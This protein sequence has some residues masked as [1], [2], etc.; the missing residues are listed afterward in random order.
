MDNLMF[1]VNSTSIVYTIEELEK[2][3]NTSNVH[4]VTFEYNYN[5]LNNKQYCSNLIEY[6][7]DK[8]NKINKKLSLPLAKDFKEMIIIQILEIIDL[9]NEKYNYLWKQLIE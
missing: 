6:D 2:I 9:E 8:F 7:L 5:L 3:I 1:T 4:T